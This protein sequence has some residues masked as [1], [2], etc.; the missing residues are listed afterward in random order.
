[1]IKTKL[2]NVR[3]KRHMSQEEI[4]DLIGMTQSTYSRKEKGITNITLQ[5]WIKLAKVLAVEKEEIYQIN[6]PKKN[7]SEILDIQNQIIPEFFLEQIDFLRK[8]N[9]ELKERLKRLEQ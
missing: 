7:I 5:E 3:L 1:M 2:Q 9:L 4:A 8:E 6:A